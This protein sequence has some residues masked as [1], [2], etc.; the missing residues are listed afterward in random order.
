MQFG[1]EFFR[2]LW[3]EFSYLHLGRS[4]FVRNRV[5][6]PAPDLSLVRSAYDEAGKVFPQF[7]P[8]KVDIAWGG[9]IDNTPD[10][11]PVVSECVQ[12]PGIYLCTGFSGHGFSSSLG[13]GRMLAQA[14]VT[15][16]TET[17]APNIIY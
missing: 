2:Q 7:D 13:A 1:G 17:L 16:E 10:G 5:L 12:H 15:G 14:I 8:S 4:P 11:I 3:N 9:A 6:D